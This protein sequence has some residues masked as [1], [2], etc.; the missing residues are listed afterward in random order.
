M[1]GMAFGVLIA[2]FSSDSFFSAF[3]VFISTYSYF[4]AMCFDLLL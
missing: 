1:F 3:R 2:I 4:S